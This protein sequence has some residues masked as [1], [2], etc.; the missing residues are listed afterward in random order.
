MIDYAAACLS[1]ANI[2]VPATAIKLT[3]P[4]EWDGPLSLTLNTGQ[5]VVAVIAGGILGGG[6]LMILSNL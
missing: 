3:L 6:A 4:P 5:T 1:D 2:T